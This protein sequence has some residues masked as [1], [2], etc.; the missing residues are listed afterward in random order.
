MK[1]ETLYLAHSW[2]CNVT[3]MKVFGYLPVTPG[4]PVPGGNDDV[5]WLSANTVPNAAPAA[6]A[7]PI[8]ISKERVWC[9]LA[10]AI[11]AP[12]G[13]AAA[14]PAVDTPSAAAAPTGSMGRFLGCGLSG[15]VLC[16]GWVV[17]GCSCCCAPVA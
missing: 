11:A 6:T 8:L 7:A 2:R 9:C 13:L 16:A 1:V 15:R 10:G 14:P 12:A 4:M 3:V 5:L 17:N